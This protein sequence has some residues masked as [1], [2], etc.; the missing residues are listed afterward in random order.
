MRRGT[1]S[2]RELT[3]HIFARIRK[4][5][6][7]I[8]AFV[9]LAEER[10]L[11]E[12]RK[13]DRRRGR[14]TALGKLHGLPVLVKDAFATAGIRTTC[15]ARAFEEY[16]PREDAAAVAR[17]RRAGAI[18]VGKTN[19]PELA[20]DHQA[21]NAIA[22]TT[23]NPWDVRRT[24]GGS[25]GGGAAA[26]AA[27]FGFLEIGS[28]IAGSIRVPSHFC[29]VY[30]HKPT[31]DLVS[32]DGHIPPVPGV[33]APQELGVAGPMARSAADLLLE[34]S[35]IAG[36]ASPRA[37][38]RSAALSRPRKARLRDYR[39]GLMLDDAFCPV[40]SDV[41][42]VLHGAAAALRHAGAQVIEGWPEGFE[43]MAAHVSYLFLLAAIVSG[44]EPDAAMA[45]IEQAAA[46]GSRDPM[47]LG[48][49]AS[50][51]LWA[52]HTEARLRT[53]ALWQN[54]FRTFDAFLLPVNF[55]SAFP[56]DPRRGSWLTD[57][58]KLR[59]AA[60]EREYT[61][62]FKWVSVATYTGCPATVAPVGLTR[63]GL[64]VGMQIMGPFL[65]DA[66]PIDIASK[67]A[68][69]CGGFVPPPDYPG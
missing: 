67:L 48:A 22:G 28:D 33:L 63:S 34:L 24:P 32:L 60:G 1:V 7:Q 20:A 45:P 15:G 68:E 61:D 49:T 3:E 65:E 30:G 58:R 2:S 10:A 4:H 26:L 13:A 16:V 64:P 39:F 40:D 54:Y 50:H 52:H 25:T 14:S 19:T 9:T 66:T 12:A 27:G 62:Q 42:E 69:V 21:Y 11:D 23:N 47:V 56:H 31:L 37:A 38:A 55:V 41:K 51:R 35:V 6:R 43:R 18:V 5:N 8:N 17:L 29:G 46:R 59:T 36:P 57:H 44:G 53:R